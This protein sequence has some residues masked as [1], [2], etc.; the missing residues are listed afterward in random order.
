MN[1]AK[2]VAA[3]L[4]QSMIVGL[5]I[6]PVSAKD[7]NVIDQKKEL[8]KV[9]K[10]VEQSQKRLDSLKNAEVNVQKQLSEYD[11][12]IATNQKLIQRLTR[13]Q[14]DLKKT[15]KQTESELANREDSY[16]HARR[17]FLGGLR[18]LYYSTRRQENSMVGDPGL[19][20]GRE[21]Q[22]KYLSAL[23]NFESENVTEAYGYLTDAIATKAT[24]V[25]ESD[26]V[27][28]LRKAKETSTKLEATK[29][30]RTESELEKLQRKKLAVVDQVLTLQQA[31]REM[32]EIVQRLERSRQRAEHDRPDPESSVFAT[33]QGK[34][35]SPF[36]G[37]I[38]QRFGEIID[39]ITNLRSFSPGIIIKGRPGATVTAVSSGMIAYVGNLRGYGNFVIINHDDIYYTTYAGLGK[40]NVSKDQYVRSGT[41]L[42]SSADDGQLRFELRQGS[43]PLDPVQWL[44][45]DTF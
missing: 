41:A 11:Q 5:A 24:L 8:I 18:Q 21:R 37:K 6:A 31:A 39:P 16:E 30:Q 35:I 23:A 12:K 32:E 25:S 34:L 14:N 29:K 26:K 33:L 10:E 7:G 45:L 17:R 15:I 40:T 38:V 20:V 28:S 9:H 27:A 42:A 36:K 3:F 2:F 19:E 43:R 4:V 22:K 44:R 1:C 13:E